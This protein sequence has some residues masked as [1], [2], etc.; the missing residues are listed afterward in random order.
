MTTRGG[1]DARYAREWLEQQAVAGLLDM[2]AQA[3]F[4]GY[5]VLAVDNVFWRFYQLTG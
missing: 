3:G 4:A 1:V 2:A 5:Q